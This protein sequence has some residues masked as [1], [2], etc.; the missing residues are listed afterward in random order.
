MLSYLDLQR[1]AS[2][3]RYFAAHCAAFGGL[4]AAAAFAVTGQWSEALTAL[5]ASLAG[6]GLPVK[7][8]A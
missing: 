2:Y 1:V 8:R 6:F 4:A 7:P 5:L 3:F